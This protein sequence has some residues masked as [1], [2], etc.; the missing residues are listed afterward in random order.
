MLKPLSISGDPKNNSTK[1]SPG[2]EPDH[3]PQHISCFLLS[4]PKNVEFKSLKDRGRCWLCCFVYVVR[5]GLKAEGVSKKEGQS[6]RCVDSA[7]IC[8][9]SKSL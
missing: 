6:A 3:Q 9:W 1:L 4:V 2:P 8:R 7:L 5:K